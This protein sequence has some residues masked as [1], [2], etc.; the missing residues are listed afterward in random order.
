MPMGP[1]RPTTSILVQ[2]M[3]LL[4]RMDSNLAEF[5]PDA[6]IRTIRRHHTVI[7]P[8]PASARDQLQLINRVHQAL[9]PVSLDARM[10]TPASALIATSQT[11]RGIFRLSTVER[12]SKRQMPP[13]NF[14]I[15]CG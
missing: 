14:R 7:T 5:L 9:R 1:L 12:M 13:A 8:F 15:P 2:Y 4:F 10:V 6:T 11:L 3:R